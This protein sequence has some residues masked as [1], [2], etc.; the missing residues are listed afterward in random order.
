MAAT[1]NDR[2]GSPW[3]AAKHHETCADLSKLLKMPD[4]VAQFYRAAGSSYIDAGRASTG[5]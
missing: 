1:A 5:V 3:H 2:M 4:K